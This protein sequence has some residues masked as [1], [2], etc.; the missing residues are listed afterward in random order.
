MP[1]SVA[2]VGG[3]ISGLAAAGALHARGLDVVLIDR[4][5][6]LGGRLG[7]RTLRGT[8]LPYDG[9]VV[10]LGASYLTADDA[11]FLELVGRW[12]ADGLARPWTDTFHVV[13]PQGL[14]GTTTGPL[15]YAAPGGLRSLADDL[16]LELPAVVNP[17]AVES[18]ERQA[19]GVLVDGERF[20]AAVLAMPDAQ[21]LDVLADDDPL[22]PRLEGVTW[23]PV[24]ALVAAFASR[25]WPD[26]V[27]GVFVN[28]DPVLSFVADDGRRRG[29]G[30][31]VL[32]AHSAPSF[33]AGHLD[34]PAGAAPGLIER[35]SEVLGV[36]APAWHEV[37]RWSLAK[38]DG[39][40][41]EPCGAE[42][43]IAVCGDSWGA[44]PRVQTAWLSGRAA[45]ESVAGL[46]A[47]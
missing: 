42:G 17:R 19:D 37:K 8:G 27:D 22:V 25:R 26:D 30:A 23:E 5:Q 41:P 6:R 28:D 2:V 7:A 44:R 18:V 14:A 24:L 9:R 33:A 13:G 32:V 12:T 31:P 10:D 47:G 40:R 35:L 15:R 3:G 38:P 39:H 36:P 1:P 43:R 21:V 16:A 11:A 20:D 45:A 29:D 34:D 46:L 4:G